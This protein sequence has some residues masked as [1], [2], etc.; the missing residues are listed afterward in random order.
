MARTLPLSASV[1][2]PQEGAKLFAPSADRN[3]QALLTLLHDHAPKT[4]QVLEIASGTGQHVTA[5]ATALSSLVWQPTELDPARCASI[6]AH[7]A[8]AGLQ[9]V[10][11]AVLLDATTRGWSATH[12]SNNLIHLSN[13]LHLIS[14]IEAQTI[15]SEAA[16]ALHPTGKIILYGPFRRGGILT[17]EGDQKF[18]AELR[19]ADPDIGYKDDL[20][21]TNWLRD[22]GLSLIKT[23]NMPANN[24]AF[25]AR[26]P[27]P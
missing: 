2:Q 12:P 25:I 1:A 27:A 7:V 11:A 13:L 22:A 15:I 5:F 14:E 20:D 3:A 8:E 18:D 6:D 23:V 17:S 21:I 9:N 4:G 10:R 19:A 24:L 26:K 16:Q